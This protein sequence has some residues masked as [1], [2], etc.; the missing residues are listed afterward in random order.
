MYV[1]VLIPI[2]TNTLRL[3]VLENVDLGLLIIAQVCV[4]YMTAMDVAINL[5]KEKKM[6]TSFLDTFVL[7]VG[8]QKMNVHV[9]NKIERGI[10]M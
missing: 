6:T 2:T 5:I 7:F 3:I 1:L 10:L 9:T 8:Q 4:I